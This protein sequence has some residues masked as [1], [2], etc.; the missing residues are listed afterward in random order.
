MTPDSPVTPVHE[1]DPS[2]V[3][4]PAGAMMEQDAEVPHRAADE[5]DSLASRQH[6]NGSA[7][8]NIIVLSDGTG[9]SS[10]KAFRT[11]VWKMYRALDLADPKK[12]KEPRQFAFYD[13][14]V[15][16]SA[17]RPLGLLGGV[18]G[19][20]LARNVRDLYAFICRTYRPG[21]RI[22]VF[23]FSRGAFT[24]RV[25]V[26]LL[27]NQGVVPYSGNEAELNR[28]VR[29]AYRAYRAERFETDFGLEVPFRWLRDRVIDGWNLIRRR[30]AYNATLN[31]GREGT[32]EELKIEFVGVWDTV[33]AYGLFRSSRERS[34]GSCGRYRC[35]TMI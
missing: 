18:F 30:P 27:L 14:G 21:D 15:G 13:N 23:G 1:E 6:A 28:L 16:T 32:E 5:D 35:S 25:L 19:V 31:R 34:I 26:G 7:P 17:F 4:S 33:A 9:N 12:L 8:R 3:P 29:A 24:V 20:G 11:N 10:A 22:Y 2:G